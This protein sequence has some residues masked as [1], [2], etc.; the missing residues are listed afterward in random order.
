MPVGSLGLCGLP[1][2]NTISTGCRHRALK[3]FEYPPHANPTKNCSRT[4]QKTSVSTAPKQAY[5]SVTAISLATTFT[6]IKNGS[7]NNNPPNLKK[8]VALAKNPASVFFTMKSSA[9]PS[10]T[11]SSE[12]NPN[13]ERHSTQRPKA[14]GEAD[15]TTI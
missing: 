2:W 3:N 13:T 4:V 9:S 8:T 14:A 15:S 10:G 1:S 6:G 7:A 5:T 11:A 12:N